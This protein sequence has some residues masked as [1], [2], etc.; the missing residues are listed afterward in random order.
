MPIGIVKI[1][2]V[3]ITAPSEDFNA[4]ILERRFDRFVFAAREAQSHVIDLA[5]GVNITGGFKQRNPLTAALEE[6]LPGALVID[7][8]SE[9]VDVKPSCASKVLDMKNNMVDPR[10]IES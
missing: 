10:Y 9:K 3:W 1:D 8:H 5:S 6:A 4:G 7:F 2:A